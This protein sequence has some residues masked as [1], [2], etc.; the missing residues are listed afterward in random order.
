MPVVPKIAPESDNQVWRVW[1]DDG[2]Q[3]GKGGLCRRVMGSLNGLNGH[4]PVCSIGLWAATRPPPMAS[5]AA[6]K[7]CIVGHPVRSV[8]CRGCGC[9]C[10]C[11]DRGGRSA[12]PLRFLR[13]LRPNLDLLAQPSSPRPDGHPRLPCHTHPDRAHLHCCVYHAHSVPCTQ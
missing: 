1:A 12:T 11:W 10:T 5:V 2:C 9:Y 7:P 8:S 6:S 4:H 3:A 13:F